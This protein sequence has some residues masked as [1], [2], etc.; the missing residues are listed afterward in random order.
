MNYFLFSVSWTK[1]EWKSILYNDCEDLLAGWQA[2]CFWQ[3]DRR[4]GRC[5]GRSSAFVGERYDMRIALHSC[6]NTFTSFTATN[7]PSRRWDRKVVH[8]WRKC[9]SRKVASYLFEELSFFTRFERV[10]LGQGLI[11]QIF[12][13]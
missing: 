11:S 6:G 10:T 1:F 9:P 12:D 7:R 2:R 5:A 8:P 13:T 4:I 3:S